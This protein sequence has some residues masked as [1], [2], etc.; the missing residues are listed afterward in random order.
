MTALQIF[1]TQ[2]HYRE[3]TEQEAQ[4]I[5]DAEHWDASKIE[6][7]EAMVAA[8]RELENGEEL[9]KQAIQ[10]RDN[11]ETNLKEA[12]KRLEAARPRRTFM[13]EWRAQRAATHY[14][15]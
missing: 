8:G 6:R 3:P 14:G 9:L 11:A 15:E 12:R 7:F 1:D 2:G 13:D 4:A 5:A 10:R